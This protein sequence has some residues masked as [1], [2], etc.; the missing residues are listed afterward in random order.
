MNG[1]EKQCCPKKILLTQQ[2]ESSEGLDSCC[3]PSDADATDNAFAFFGQ[4]FQ[5]NL[6][7]WTA[8]ISPA[9]L[10]SS[11]STWLWQLAQ[12]PEVLWELA[13][14]PVF[15]A[16]DC[17]NN[18]ICVDRAAGGKDVRFKKDSWQ[19]M[20][21]RLYAE[22][23]L[24]VEDWWRRA[25]TKV[26]GLPSQVERTVS[27]W[28]RQYLDAL[29]PSNCVWSN[30]D[31]FH[32]AIR[33]GGLN[34]IQGSQIAME[35]S[36]EKLTGA[37]PT[38]SEHFIPG[39]D[40]A[41]TPGRVVFQNHLIELIQYE[42]LT[43]TV[44]K[45]P[46]LVLP[47]WIMKYY[48]LDLSPHNSL[49]KWLV[50]QGHTVFIIS[51]RNPDKED[52]D[53]GMDDYYRQGAM[54]AIDAVSATLPQTKIN[55]M[56]Y[57]LGGTL[58]MIT[59][60]AMSRDK[61]ERLNSLTLLA[62]QGDFTEAGELML[63]VTESQVAFLKNMMGE[64]GY[65]DTKQMAGSFQ[66]LRAYDLIWSKM[67][68]DYMHGMRR[69]MIDLTAWNA[70]AT[71]MPYKMHSEYLEKLFLNNDFAEGRYTVEGKPVAAENIQLPVF[72]VST[73]KDH[74]APWQSVYKIHLMTEGDITFV[75][76]GGGH[77]AG[78]VSEPGHP[79]RSYRV[80]ESKKGDAYLNP[81]SWLAIAEK[82]EDS[83]WQEWHDWLVQQSTKKRVPALVINASLPAAPG[84]YVLQK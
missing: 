80:H 66:M 84:T 65:L 40:V 32:E 36:L 61:D 23:F 62:A 55:L 14:Y 3:A 63:F 58:A 68:Q 22:G 74:V 59:A 42:A 38:G 54:A 37:P 50:R 7:K 77:N 47:A 67:V 15:H 64:Q 2:E 12:S 18:I 6:A 20:P 52:R 1:L 13:F 76:T 44:Y 46:I 49:V 5:A 82:Q 19:P 72:A 30:P 10:G 26:P 75:L 41:I 73:E 56:G 17:I 27:F 39:K 28:A 81:E 8:G 60:A 45:E 31:L 25:T 21:W 51:W 83:W 78:I 16:N 24:Q 71:R 11:Y 43:K 29:S 48:I 70:D 79:G 33:T 69:G 57:C 53:L 9:A 35:D 34:L 4:L